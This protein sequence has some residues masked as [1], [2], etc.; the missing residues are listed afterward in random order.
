ML[1]TIVAFVISI[2][3]IL[4]CLG[5]IVFFVLRVFINGYIGKKVV[6]IAFTYVLCYV[7]S[8]FV[9]LSFEQITSDS[10]TTWQLIA[11]S[12]TQQNY[13]VSIVTSFWNALKMM[14]LSFDGAK[15]SAFFNVDVWGGL[16]G[17]AYILTSLTG[18]AFISLA[19]IMLFVKTAAI[20]VKNFFL[21]V[22]TKK[23]VYFIFSDPKVTIAK[24]IG[25]SL[26]LKN[27]KRKVK[28]NVKKE[29]LINFYL[30]KLRNEKIVI[31]VVTRSSLQTQEGTE[32]KDSLVAS[33]FEV[34]TE[35]YSDK[36]A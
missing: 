22:F 13:A 36:F 4:V 19:V 15:V 35:N 24:K 6:F 26:S 20:N 3:S 16:F 10:G 32:Y 14:S 23:D 1:Q 29:S 7:F 11:N 31:M 30:R 12:P 17:S 34:S 9:N 33:G 25:E 5:M 28:E 21:K 2:L 27:E 8:L 18:A